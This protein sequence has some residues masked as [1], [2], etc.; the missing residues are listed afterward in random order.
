MLLLKTLG[1]C[2]REIRRINSQAI[3]PE[4]IKVSIKQEGVLT[5]SRSAMTIRN[6]DL[7]MDYIEL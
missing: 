4:G 1:Y 7:C 6:T 3:N 5:V 2:K